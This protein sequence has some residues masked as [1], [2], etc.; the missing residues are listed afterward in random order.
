MIRRAA[1]GALERRG[2]NPTL[3]WGDSTPPPN[4]MIGSNVAGISVTQQ[5]AVQIAAVYGCCGLLADSVSTLPFRWLDGPT[6]ATAKELPT[7][8]L[9]EQPYAEISLTDWLAQFVWSLA[10]RGNF[11]GLIIE[12]DKNLYPTQI[13]PIPPD[14]V[15][16]RRNWRGEIE[17]RFYGVVMNLDDVIHV[18]YQS[19]PGAIIG[20]NPIEVMRY[21]FGLARA[22]DM[23]G[24]SYFLNSATP[25]GV[26]EVNGPL[27]VNE[28]KAM[29]R[30]WLA[31]HQGLNQANLPAILTDGAS[32]KPIMITPEDSQFLQSRGYTESQICGRIFRVPPHMVGIVD[33]TTS[34]GSGIEQQERGYATNTLAPYITRVER[35]FTSM[36][37][38]GMYANLNLTHRLRGDSLQ[39]AQTGSLGMLAGFFCADDV[40]AMYDLPPVPDGKGQEFY[41]PINTE[42]MELAE[43]QVEAAIKA[44]EAPPPEPGQPAPPPPSTA[45]PKPRPGGGGGTRANDYAVLLREIRDWRATMERRALAPPPPPPAPPPAINV[46]VAPPNVHVDMPAI[47]VEPA[48]VYLSPPDVRIAPA[49]I[50]VHT[51]EVRVEPQ[52][53]VA[54]APAP[55]VYIGD[56]NVSIAMP[57]PASSKVVRDKDGRIAGVE[58]PAVR[59][60]GPDQ[61]V[62]TVPGRT[63]RV[64]RD[65]A[66]RI[67]G[68]EQVEVVE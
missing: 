37:P 25:S 2:A 36:S 24:E 14:N 66:G 62:L 47:K 54:A 11:Y 43:A 4:S 3:P 30:N 56:R 26:I 63:S 67:T 60:E 35:L 7:N 32:F 17:Y 6:L 15:Q 39:R 13:K 61:L 12:R 65:R 19:P 31:A 51:P 57:A 10:L 23:Y 48:Q 46:H 52:I 49:R 53:T 34:W 8:Q 45:R 28:T 58:V 16:V 33:R 42:L 68:V 55:D 29:M 21:P 9:I 64:V 22:M 5:S 44:N 27:D 20:W 41:V 18:R 40:R 38:D 59:V 1:R 50:E